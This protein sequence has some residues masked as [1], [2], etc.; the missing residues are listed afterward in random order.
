MGAGFGSSSAGGFSWGWD[1]W[2]RKKVDLETPRFTTVKEAYNSIARPVLISPNW[3]KGCE[4]VI[5]QTGQVRLNS[6]SQV[7]FP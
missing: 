2:F 3:T 4:S 5:V 7:L 6:A 1:P